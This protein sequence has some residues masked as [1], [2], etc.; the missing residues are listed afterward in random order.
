[1]A[2]LG[3]G[4]TAC[5]ASS[6]PSTS[7]PSAVTLV[8]GIQTDPNWWFPITSLAGCSTSNF[9]INLL[10]RPLLYVTPQETIDYSRSI[11]QS[12]TPSQNDTV[13][14]IRLKPS[15]HW[16]NGQ[17]ITA[18]DVVYAWRI[19]DAASQP[20]AVWTACGAGTGGIPRDW[21]SVTTNGAHTVVV[22]TT[23]PVSPTWFE[24][25]GLD[26]MVPIPKAVWDHSSNMRQELSWI[27]AQS[28]RPLSALYRVIDG[29]YQLTKYVNNEYWTFK[30]NP[31]YSGHLASI[32]TLTFLYETGDQ[33]VYAAL[34]KGTLSTAQLP[35]EYS[36]NR[37]Q[38]VAKGYAA[39]SAPYQF[40]INFI[41]PNESPQTPVLGNLFSQLY[42]RQA[43]EMGIDQTT[44]AQKLYGGF[45]AVDFS[46]VPAKPANAFYDPHVPRTAY[47]PAAGT[48]LMEAHGWRM[49]NGVLEKNSV[50]FKFTMLYMS[51]NTTD[52]NVVQLL[53]ADWAREGIDV[54]LKSEPFNQ[55]IAIA[56]QTDPT[57]WQMAWW[58]LGIFY[59]PDY[60]PTGGSL[61]GS[62]VPNNFGDYANTRMDQLIAAT[63][64]PGTLQQ[65]Q[66]RMDQYQMYW[67]AQLPVLPL[68]E[69]TGS[70]GVPAPYEVVKP[71][72][73][74]VIKWYNPIFG[75]SYNR[76]TISGT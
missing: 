30:G 18:Q 71:W 48:R 19:L 2:A 63:Y 5:G 47:N 44:I 14:T 25:N 4:I 69:Y 60:F 49:V 51:G 3:L 34:L 54:T 6:A 67:A 57:K 41:Q 35:P 43:L 22:T 11:A 16:S 64:A 52:N 9:G 24:I 38:L 65:E 59:G 76:W 39:K 12:V 46:P 26:E 1:M 15:W 56:N 31:H 7:R 72:L 50:P 20:N 21:K 37:S 58:G 27:Q 55:V 73:H 33:G 62:G 61:W 29:P 10:Y 36:R 28:N 17:P 13:F 45:A 8:G 66:Q 42:V 75:E 74:G 53:K 68:P 70:G 32:K 23:K 40:A